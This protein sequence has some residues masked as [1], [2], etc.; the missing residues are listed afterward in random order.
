MLN[1][2]P[3]MLNSMSWSRITHR[4]F[5]SQFAYH[6]SI[7]VHLHELTT[8]I[9][10]FQNVISS[11][12]RSH[13]LRAPYVQDLATA[14]FE[15]YKMCKDP[16]DIEQSILRFTEAIFLP[17]PWDGRCQ[18]IVQIFFA[19]T[20]ALVFRGDKKSRKFEDVTRS[21]IHLHYLRRQSLEAFHIPPS[22]V[23]GLLVAALEIQMNMKLGDEWQDIEEMAVLCHELLKSDMTTTFVT[24]YIMGLVRAVKAQLIRWTGRREPSDKVIECLREAN[25]RLPD[26]YQ[27]SMMLAW[28]L[29]VRFGITHSND[30]CEEAMAILDKVIRSPGDRPTQDQEIALLFVA[31]F[32]RT[33]SDMFGK[34]EYL[35]QAIYRTRTF[36][37]ETTFEDTLHP[38]GTYILARLMGDRFDDSGVTSD[39]Q[40]P[41]LMNLGFSDHPHPSFQDLTAS[42]TELNADNNVK[43]LDVILSLHRFTLLTDE[44]QLVEAVKY[45][46]LLLSSSHHSSEFAHL[47]SK[48]LGILLP[49]AFFCTDKIEYLNE[50]ISVLRENLNTQGTLD[51]KFSLNQRLI[52]A[53]FI[54][55]KL[56]H[57]WEDFNEMMQLFPIAVNDERARTPDRSLL[58]CHWTRIAHAF[59]HPSTLAAYDCAILLM[60]ETLTFAPTLD[61]Q[62]F[63]LVKMRNSYETLPLDHAS[64]HISTGQLP[65][66]IETLERGRALIWS[67]MRGLRTSIDQIH[68][69]DSR[70]AEKFAAVN[71]DLETL[72]LTISANRNGDGPG[73]N[74]MGMDPFGQL[75][76]QQRKLLDDRSKLILQIRSLP[77]FETFLK[78]PSFDNLHSA[79]ARGP[80]IIINHSRWRSDIIIL[81]HDSP[82]S[83]IPTAD[84]FYNRAVN[85]RDQLLDARKEGL[86]SNEYEGALS[87]VLKELYE[88]V[89]RPVIQRLNELRVQE[90]SRVWWCPTSVFCSLPL[91]AMGPIPSDDGPPQYFLDLYIP[92]YISTLSTLIESN[93]P[94]SDT[95]GKPSI[96]LVSRPDAS[97][98]GASGEMRV[99]QASSFQVAT[100]SS[101]TATPTT[102][103]ENLRDHRFVHIICHGILEPGKPFDASFKLYGDRRLSLLDIVRSQLPEAEFAFLSACHTAELT[104]ESIADEGLHLAAAMQYCGFRSVVGT[105]WAMADEDGRD[106]AENFYKRVFSGGNKGARY[107]EW[108]AKSLRDAVKMLRRKRGMNLERWVNFVHYGA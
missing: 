68:A 63:R 72:T 3:W 94:G 99:V 60:Q 102:V 88:L 61:T 36:L 74:F 84:D 51:T 65:R 105:M 52:S 18:N 71:R 50:T 73:G 81:L 42:L 56:L 22:R 14:L 35:E 78:S 16:D 59:G 7:L 95:L 23:T 97:L 62:H 34:S 104:E 19:L 76:V 24:G 87:F 108:T 80:V 86:D 1:I 4:P 67:E 43:H 101:A 17:L 75:V 5:S 47:A 90:Q 39:L 20:L 21:I 9:S 13:T 57:R 29:Y 27:V 10:F 32:A 107:Y 82:P 91:H 11:I 2:E 28:S 49:R 40:E 41:N 15:R 66:A 44:A 55:F 37:G 106:L 96:L 70:L 33:R 93:N 31:L 83:L 46:R 85:L 12:S 58:S 64:Y 48:T 26:S 69:V 53:M 89:G 8:D 98:P 30:D 25:I 92:S 77:G 54:R 100:L 79:A 6:L 103:L 38:I 45:C